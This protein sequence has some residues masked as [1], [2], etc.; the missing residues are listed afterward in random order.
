[1]ST[2]YIKQARTQYTPQ[3]YLGINLFQPE[4]SKNL[5][6]IFKLGQLCRKKIGRENVNAFLV[7]L[8]R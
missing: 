1:M 8:S 6:D 3:I 5:E 4:I 2:S 7:P